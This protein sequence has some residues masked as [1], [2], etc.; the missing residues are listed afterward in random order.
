MNFHQK[1]QNLWLYKVR[2]SFFKLKFKKQF[3]WKLLISKSKYCEFSLFKSKSK[4]FS[5]N[6][7]EWLIK[8]YLIT[9]ILLALL[10]PAST[11]RGGAD[12]ASL[13]F[14]KWCHHQDHQEG[15]NSRKPGDGRTRTKVQ[16]YLEFFRGTGDGENQFKL[17]FNIRKTP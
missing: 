7:P 5:W 6:F 11:S 15:L 17:V 10:T 2:N 14:S 12:A 3:N 1:I 16:N 8:F 9:L 13:Y 4:Y